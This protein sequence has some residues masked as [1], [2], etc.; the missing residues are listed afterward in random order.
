MNCPVLLDFTILISPSHMDSIGSFTQ[1]KSKVEDQ[2]PVTWN[3]EDANAVNM[4]INTT[5]C[6]LPMAT[7]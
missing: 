6:Y 5:A 2:C 1:G 7:F 3:I 4:F